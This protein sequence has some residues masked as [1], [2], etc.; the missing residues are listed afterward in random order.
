MTGA[1]TAIEVGTLGG[2]SAWHILRGL[3][4]EGRLITIELD[5]RAAEVARQNL[6]QA[7]VG[8]RVRYEVGPA[9]KVLPRLAAEIRPRSVGFVFL[10]ADKK[11]Y[12]AY[13][14][15]LRPLLADGGLLVADNV[16]GTGNW[17]I[18]HEEHPSRRAVDA[19]NRAIVADPDLEV[20]GLLA[21]QGLLLARRRRA[22]EP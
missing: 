20:A 15:A 5:P 9:T 2:Y 16:L 6:A 21:R 7:G 11:E 12:P 3:G 19:F 10:D 17:W 13:W 8:D 4:P 1:R 22:G 14:A 18:D